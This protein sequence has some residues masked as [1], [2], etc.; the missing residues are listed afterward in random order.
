MGQ[1]ITH[2][3]VYFLITRMLVLYHEL[4]YSV[5]SDFTS[6]SSNVLLLFQD[7]IW[8]TTLCLVIMS[9]Y[10]FL[11]CDSFSFY[12]SFQ[13]CQGHE[14]LLEFCRMSFSLSVSD[15][16]SWLNWDYGFG[17]R[18]PP[19]WSALFITHSKGYVIN[20]TL[21]IMLTM[22]ISL[23]WCLHCNATIFSFPYSILWKKAT[24]SSPQ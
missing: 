20:R 15:V 2:Q 21:S 12:L 17:W 9:S 16:S 5:Y 13:K 19:R 14:R 11:I 3:F 22:I 1:K 4:S 6:F 7:L 10:C 8:D 24:K 18:I 23:R